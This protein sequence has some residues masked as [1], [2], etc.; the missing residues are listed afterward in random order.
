MIGG[1]EGCQAYIDGIFVYSDNWDWHVN[2]LS[3]FC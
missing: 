2:Q 3:E 1:L